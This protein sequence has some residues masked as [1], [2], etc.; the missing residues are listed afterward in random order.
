MYIGIGSPGLE[1]PPTSSDP[2]KVSSILLKFKPLGSHLTL[3]R[4]CF[5]CYWI[6]NLIKKLVVIQK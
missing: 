5:I 2:M 1:I 4:E 6:K 3:I